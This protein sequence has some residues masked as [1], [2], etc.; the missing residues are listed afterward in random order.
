MSWEDNNLTPKFFYCFNREWLS[1]FMLVFRRCRLQAAGESCSLLW[2]FCWSSRCSIFGSAA[3]AKLGRCGFFPETASER[4]K[5]DTKWKLGRAMRICSASSSM[6]ELL[7]LT[8][9]QKD[10]TRAK[11]EYPVAQILF[12]TSRII[13]LKFLFLIFLFC[14]FQLISKIPAFFLLFLIVYWWIYVILGRK[15]G[16]FWYLKC[17]P[18]MEDPKE[19]KKRTIM[20]CIEAEILALQ[21]WSILVTLYCF[22]LSVL[23]LH[24]PF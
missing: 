13:S 1:N 14:F 18:W 20:M 21:Y 19:K 23:S 12:I 16:V 7:L 5:G 4:R 24:K 11:E 8:E 15:P 6:E 10:L 3:T 2:W 9:L 22:N 17:F